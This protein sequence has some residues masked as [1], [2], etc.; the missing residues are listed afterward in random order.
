MLHL[1][2]Q[3]APAAVSSQLQTMYAPLAIVLAVLP[4]VDS[5]SLPAGEERSGEIYSGFTIHR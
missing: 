1:I 4:S 5:V 3:A 2:D